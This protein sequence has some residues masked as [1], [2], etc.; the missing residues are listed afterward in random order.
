MLGQRRF[1]G[2]LD[3]ILFVSVI[4]SRSLNEQAELRIFFDQLRDCD[5]ISVLEELRSAGLTRKVSL[6]NS[7]LQFRPS[8]LT[9]N[10]T[11]LS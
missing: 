4:N 3:H 8:T 2:L 7:A 11:H 9:S 5:G 6:R 1:K 10:P